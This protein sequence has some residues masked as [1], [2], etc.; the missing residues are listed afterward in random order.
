MRE[1]KTERG[2]WWAGGWRI[3]LVVL[4][5][6]GISAAAWGISVA[7]SGPKGRGDQIKQINKASN[8]TFSQEQFHQLIN[9]IKG[10]DQQIAVQVEA[11]EAHPTQD[12]ERNRLFAVVTGLRNQCISTR[13]QYDAEA[14]KISREKFRDADL[15]E[16]IGN[17]QPQS[18][19]DCRKEAA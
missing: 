16:Q 15:P 5:I 14:R 19:V 11:L 18:E 13:Q 6:L 8:R 3:G 7:V 4:I 9:D 17:Y 2:W 1:P 10:Y 12:E